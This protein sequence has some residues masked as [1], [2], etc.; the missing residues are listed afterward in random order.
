MYRTTGWALSLSVEECPQCNGFLLYRC[1]CNNEFLPKP[2]SAKT[3]HHFYIIFTDGACTN[4]GQLRAK[5]GVGV[6]Y[7]NDDGSQLSKLITDIVDNFAL[8]SN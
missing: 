3:C 5:V 4:N 1:S 7:I 2:G 8:R 6:A